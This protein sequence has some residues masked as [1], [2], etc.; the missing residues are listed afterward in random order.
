MSREIVWIH[1]C[2]AIVGCKRRIKG[3]TLSRNRASGRF[4]CGRILALAKESPGVLSQCWLCALHCCGV[5]HIV[6]QNTQKKKKQCLDPI[7]KFMIV[8][9]CYHSSMVALS[10]VS[11]TGFAVFFFHLFSMI[12]DNMRFRST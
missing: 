8:N 2:S 5:C 7:D 12:S 4:G 1:S 11:C 6:C 3:G 10:T 9:R